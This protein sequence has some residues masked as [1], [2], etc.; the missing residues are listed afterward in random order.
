MYKKLTV[1]DSAGSFLILFLLLIIYVVFPVKSSTIDAY[2]FAF[3]VKEGVE[4]FLPHHLLYNYLGFIWVK[5]LSL[6][7]TFDVLASLKVMNALMAT[8]SLY[9][10]GLVL[11]ERGVRISHR[12]NWLLLVGSTWGVMRFATENE[13]YLAPILFSLWGSFYFG[14]YCSRGNSRDLFLSGTLTAFAALVHQIHFFWWLG[15]LMAL[16]FYRKSFVSAIKY[17]LPAL[18]VP[19]VYL[20]VIRFYYHIPLSVQSIAEFIL[21]DYYSGSAS[22]EFGLINFILTPISLFRTFAQVHGY[23]VFLWYFNP[24]YLV[25]AGIAILLLLTALFYIR[26][27]RLSDV[28]RRNLFIGAHGIAFLLHLGFAF[29]SHGNA[30]FM[31]MMPF[32][33]A[34][35]F[36]TV[37]QNHVKFIGFLAAGLLIWNLSVGVIPL[38]QHD[39]D[40]NH[41]MTK[42][43]L[44]SL[45]KRGGA[46]YFVIYNRPGTI[47]TVRYFSG[48]HYERNFKGAES[49]N[50]NNLKKSIDSL[51]VQKIPVFT[52]C[53]NRPSTLSRAYVIH[54]DNSAFYS[55][56]NAI[57]ADSVQT[58]SGKFYLYQLMPAGQ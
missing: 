30:E 31:V 23:L 22:T 3:Q 54:G 52:N 20:L 58:L 1:S 51:L 18:M 26:K 14:R 46:Y 50:N 49:G 42:H 10:L 25:G 56:Y 6:F 13:S 33:L 47:N 35:V 7:G 38:N 43:L 36:A 9:L 16:L 53:I 5:L 21:S 41:M 17:T 12:L 24:A 27:I 39:V 19:L 57:P 32:L 45:E 37:L 8:V 11:K 28:W 55:G 34:I 4:L 15:L 48:V 2:G 40:D 44:N 29:F